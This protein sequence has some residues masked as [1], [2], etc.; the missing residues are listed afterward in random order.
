MI[1]EPK[2]INY[3]DLPNLSKKQLEAHSL[4]YSGYV[5]K[6]NEID[7]KLNELD[8]R[9]GNTTYSDYRELKIEQSFAENAVMLHELYFENMGGDGTPSEAIMIKLSEN[10]QSFQ[11]FQLEL[12]DA[13]LSARGWVILGLD[14][15]GALRLHL[16][17]AHNM[18]GIWGSKLILV[19]DVYEHAYFIDFATDRKRYI[20]GFIEN[21]NWDVVE[22]R[23]F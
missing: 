21:I 23:L 20:D 6:L 1:H 2:N 3:E 22:A 16:C 10:F 14:P 8:S 11:D 15:D 4:L 7:N 19:L 12:M 17:D 13:G 9:K 5:K 18:N